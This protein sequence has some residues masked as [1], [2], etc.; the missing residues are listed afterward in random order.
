[1]RPDVLVVGDMLATVREEFPDVLVKFSGAEEAATSLLG[2]GDKPPLRFGVRFL[3]NRFVVE[4]VEGEIFG[5]QP[6][7]AIKT[8]EGHYYHDNLDVV[9]PRRKWAYTLDAQTIMMECVME[10]GVGSAGKFGGFDVAKLEL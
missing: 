1:M 2:F 10:I 3:E 5:P 4:V 8:K 6:F 9:E 7:L